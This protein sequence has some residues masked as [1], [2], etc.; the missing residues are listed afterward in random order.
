[1]QSGIRVSIRE[2]G[3][4]VCE[5]KSGERRAESVGF[6]EIFFWQLRKEPMTVGRG[7]M[8]VGPSGIGI[9]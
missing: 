1:M 4:L 5:P 9:E 3:V 7:S 2:P 6:F 8:T